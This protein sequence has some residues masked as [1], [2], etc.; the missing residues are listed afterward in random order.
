MSISEHI[1]PPLLPPPPPAIT[2]LPLSPPHR[3]LQENTIQISLTDTLLVLNTSSSSLSLPM[4][5]N[6]SRRHVTQSRPPPPSTTGIGGLTGPRVIQPMRRTLGQHL[7]AGRRM[8][9]FGGERNYSPVNI[10]P[11][12]CVGEL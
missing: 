3:H 9:G 6:T 5:P 7:T 10:L 2:S 8:K 12:L 4:Q 11:A 1:P